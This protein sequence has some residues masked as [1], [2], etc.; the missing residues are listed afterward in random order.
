MDTKT[1]RIRVEDQDPTKLVYDRHCIAQDFS[2]K[3]GNIFVDA[4]YSQSDDEFGV[5]VRDN[6]DRD[7]VI[8]ALKRICKE[9]NIR[10]HTSHGDNG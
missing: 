2:A 8:A 6:A 10:P 7:S 5:R 9:N 4:W 3:Q 1:I